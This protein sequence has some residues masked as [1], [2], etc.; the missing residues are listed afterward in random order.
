MNR[1][2]VG[3]IISVFSVLTVLFVHYSCTEEVPKV[4]DNTV[5]SLE[6]A[7]LRIESSS[8]KFNTYEQS[9]QNITVKSN[10]VAWEFANIPDW[11]S[12]SPASGSKNSNQ[13][14]TITC[15]AN[16]DVKDRMGVFIF[17]SRGDEWNYSTTVTVSQ[18]RNVYEAIPETDS[19]GFPY[20]A[21]QA[22]VHVNANN[23][24]WTVSI[25]QEM[26]SWCAVS[27][28]DNEVLINCSE[29]ASVNPRSGYMYISTADGSRRVKIFQSAIKMG[30]S[31]ADNDSLTLN[32]SDKAG[33]ASINVNT[34]PKIPWT[35]TSS[36]DWIT[37]YPTQ[38]VGSGTINVSVTEN[39]EG[40]VRTAKVIVQAYDFVQEVTVIQNG[41]YLNVTS[42]SL[43][44]GSKGGEIMLSLKSNDGWRAQKDA[45]W[46]I[47]SE[48]QGDGDCNVQLTV[49]DNNFLTGRSGT[50]TITPNIAIPVVLNIEQ[51]GRHLAISDSSTIV[52]GHGGVAK[53]KIYVDTDSE[54]DVTTGCEYISVTKEEGSF[55]LSMIDFN[56]TQPIKD[57]VT[58]SLTGL[59]A[60]TTLVKK[61][62][63]E[64]YGINREYVD[65][66]L[67]VMWAT[68]NVGALRS[69]EYG[70]YYAWGEIEP[71]YES[72][73]AQSNNLVWKYGKG[74]G[75]IWDSYKY[76]NGSS[77]SLTKYCSNAAYGQDGFTDGKKT[78]DPE[79]DVAHVE[80]GGNWRMPTNEEFVELLS[81]C[82]WI[83]TI[84]DG[85]K[86]YKVASKKTGF[87]NR[88][89][90]LPA[91]GFYSNTACSDVGLRGYYCS[92]ALVSAEEVYMMCFDPTYQ[93]NYTYYYRCF[94][95]SIRPVCPIADSLIS[96]IE[97]DYK[98][99]KLVIGGD[100]RLTASAFKNDG[101]SI[102]LS[103]IEW[104]SSDV[105]VATVS[106]DGTVKAIGPGTCMVTVTYGPHSDN[107]TITVIDPAT[108]TPEYV[109][110]GLSVKWAT[111][112]V[113]AYSPEMYGDY[114][115]WGETET[116]YESGYAQSVNPVWKSSYSSGYG[117]DGYKYC[118]SGTES[119][120][121]K[122]CYNGGYGKSGFVDYK[123]VLEP[124][125]DVAYVKW[126]KN[127]RI[128]SK[129]E[130]DELIRNCNWEWTIQ[131]GVKGCK[132]TSKKAGY[133]DRSIFLPASGYRMYTSLYYL[134]TEGRYWSSSLSNIRPSLGCEY[135]FNTSSYGWDS[136][137]DRFIAHPIRP[138]YTYS[139][140]DIERIEI[141]H[142]ELNLLLNLNLN[143]SAQLTVC[144]YATDG[145]SIQIYNA[146]WS[147]SNESV[148]TVLNGTVTPV[149]EGSCTITVTYGEPGHNFTATCLVNVTVPNK[150]L[151][152]FT[153]N[154]YL[155]ANDYIDGERCA[156]VQPR[157]VTDPKDAD[158]KC[159]VVT[160]NN[161]PNNYN[162]AQLFIVSKGELYVG[163]EL[164]ISFRYRAVLD[165]ESHTEVHSSPGVWY[166]TNPL[167]YISFESEWKT[168]TYKYT[169]VNST[170]R[171]FV[172]DLSELNDINNCYFDDF[173]MVSSRTGTT[174]PEEFVATG[175]YNNHDYVDLGL[176]VKW[177][178]CNVGAYYFTE[179]GD[180]FAWGETK[181]KSTY[182]WESYCLKT[183]GS[184]FSDV[185]LSKYNMGDWPGVDDDKNVL[186][187]EDDVVH[188]KWGGNWRMPTIDEFQE[189]YDNC[190]WTWTT[191]N[192]IY[193]FKLTS[194]KPGYTQRYIFLPVTGSRNNLEWS[195][196]I[197]DSEG[198]YWSSSLFEEKST[199][200]LIFHFS[201]AYSGSF[202]EQGRCYGQAIRPVFP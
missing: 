147:S 62:A 161:N 190:T 41:K 69:E 7:A 121:T 175:T 181:I 154:I 193:G 135:S 191:M 98:N 180:H 146:Q 74:S 79:D 119:E 172:I 54:Y 11:I 178:T 37:L 150:E 113:G 40:P 139:I 137:C 55:T 89:I 201:S 111:F 26:E 2:I 182:N 156:H 170:V 84:Q 188:V 31:V 91:A 4:L 148:A 67:S 167:G 68:C 14:V 101:S 200:A 142:S 88:S 117:W 166:D 38:G 45:E 73:Y 134:N 65:L 114:Y 78:L 86:G 132:V 23:D 107:C 29:N 165:Q 43:S 124:E 169:V 35:A 60:G 52:F 103:G 85:V 109:D 28:N 194:T 64:L 90:F 53:K 151:V 115:A 185:V 104:I 138:V 44:F 118:G 179:P 162:D 75:Y 168:F 153:D 46:F 87:S 122:Y 163:D 152:V 131:D 50:I 20:T 127:W 144:G 9:S 16:P 155:L 202:F 192:G 61:I 10:N 96:R 72:G 97:L 57:T 27:K 32:F 66:G 95:L 13:S 93:N 184:S 63:V 42:P 47:L 112:N 128:P 105:N 99:K 199:Y 196:L 82:T 195:G 17:R 6:P 59:P 39:A 158:N 189:L 130:F 51:A 18:V 3:H 15:E 30:V 173:Y 198:F 21:S 49:A 76:C 83:W 186:D 58:V 108:V 140:D 183:E 126:G 106:S 164:S 133:T 176:S 197:S 92:N 5:F 25:G 100:V 24:I 22:V 33:R 157:I 48:Y 187:L 125:D 141:N 174:P 123:T 70:D 159:V 81:E 94:G 102:A 177:A 19:I 129:E 56:A 120:M 12:I 36:A 116:H 71:Y 171:T 145:G 143:N 110:L 34:L 77:F 80:W 149:G 1:K 136:D 160:T 8:I